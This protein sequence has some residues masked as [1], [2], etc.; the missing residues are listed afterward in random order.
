MTILRLFWLDVL[1]VLSIHLMSFFIILPALLAFNSWFVSIAY[2]VYLY[3]VPYGMFSY[4]DNIIADNLYGALPVRREQIVAARYLF[5]IFC[6]VLMLALMLAIN[7]SFCLLFAQP[8]LAEDFL[9][10]LTLGFVMGLVFICVAF[11]L[12]MRL[13]LR[14]ANRNVLMVFVLDFII[15][16]LYGD[17][18][19]Y[20]RELPQINARTLAVFCFL[21]LIVSYTLAVKF[22]GKREFFDYVPLGVVQRARKSR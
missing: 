17:N 20:M 16:G 22:F 8:L 13:G 12:V 19:R 7:T 9:V 5:A 11:P 14:K 18:L 15:L 1:K 2:L 6:M 21:A 4:D 10:S 3:L